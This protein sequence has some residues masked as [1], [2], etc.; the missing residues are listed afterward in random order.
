MDVSTCLQLMECGLRGDH[1]HAL[2]RAIPILLLLRPELEHVRIRHHH[3]MAEQLAS[4]AL[5]ELCR[6]TKVSRNQKCA[7][8]LIFKGILGEVASL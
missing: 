5:R 7:L 8:Y 1:G 4:E 3:P 2:A 6:V